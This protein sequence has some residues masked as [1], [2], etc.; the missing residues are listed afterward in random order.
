MSRDRFRPQISKSARVNHKAQILGKVFIGENANIGFSEILSEGEHQ[1]SIGKNTTIRDLVLITACQLDY[2]LHEVKSNG[3]QDVFIGDE[4]FISS[5]VSIYGPVIVGEKTF[6]GKNT[7]I[8][9]SKISSNCVIEDDV[10]IKNVNIP[11][12]SF[13]PRRSVIE[14]KEDLKKNTLTR[15]TADYCELN[16]LVNNV[17]FE[18]G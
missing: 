15:I 3:V 11:A 10:T 18:L 5:D 4:V 1:I 2:D 12:E 16:Y 14:S 17:C 13:I 6:I 8:F 7:K 9:N